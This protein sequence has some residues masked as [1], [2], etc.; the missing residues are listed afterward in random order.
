MAGDVESGAQASP[1]RDPEKQVRYDQRQLPCA[2]SG[3]SASHSPVK[4]DLS[5]RSVALR[6]A[7]GGAPREG[8][9]LSGAQFGACATVACVWCCRA[10][11]SNLARPARAAARHAHRNCHV[12]RGVR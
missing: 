8:G 9:S 2:L 3:C 5:P 12:S 6:E 4:I 10:A 7:R 1:A 11:H